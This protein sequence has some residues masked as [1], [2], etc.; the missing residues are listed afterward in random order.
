MGCCCGVVGTTRFIAVIGILLSL[1][2]IAGPT[3]VFFTSQ[4]YS[5]LLPFLSY[6]HKLLSEEF[7]RKG[8]TEKVQIQ[9]RGLL[10]MMHSE[11]GVLVTVV[12][13]ATNILMDLLLLFGACC[14]IR[15][16]A[17]PWLVF[18]LISILI[19]GCPAVIFFALLGLYL[20]GEGL[21]IP[22]I[23]SFSAPTVL[24]SICLALWLVVLIAYRKMGKPLSFAEEDQR[25]LEVQPLM[26]NESQVGGATSYNLGHYP[27][28]YPP[29]HPSSQPVV[30]PTAPP[31]TTP[32]DKNNPHLYPTLPA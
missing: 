24:V 30:G 16:L 23:L 31:Q 15:C 10:N 28:Y 14:R 4:D 5:E 27:Q 1:A 8:L 3:Y 25:D 12:V 19:L 9:I 22:A 7:E 20:F 17:L 11:V 18:S 32:T 6:L 13:A 29:H 21:M 26:S 2:V